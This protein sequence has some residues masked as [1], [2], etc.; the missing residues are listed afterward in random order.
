MKVRFSLLCFSFSVYPLSLPRLPLLSSPLARV[1]KQKALAPPSPVPMGVKATRMMKGDGGHRPTCSSV[2]SNR[3]GKRSGGVCRQPSMA[4]RSGGEE[5]WRRQLSCKTKSGPF[6]LLMLDTGGPNYK[7][8]IRA[9]HNLNR[10]EQRF[11]YRAKD[12][13]LSS[14]VEDSW[15]RKGTAT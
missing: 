13:E 6:F 8:S 3:P 7:L 15:A 5:R 11:S 1:N 14:Q 10:F 4:K 2:D 12:T 9:K